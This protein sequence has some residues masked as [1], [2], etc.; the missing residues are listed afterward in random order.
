MESLQVDRLTFF[1]MMRK[2]MLSSL[3]TSLIDMAILLK[4]NQDNLSDIII[5][6]KKNIRINLS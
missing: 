1:Y 6:E 3:K 2:G 5:S 4:S